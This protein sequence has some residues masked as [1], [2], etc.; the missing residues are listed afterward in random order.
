MKS[1]GLEA[2]FHMG[3]CATAR[4]CAANPCNGRTIF[5][6]APDIPES[7]PSSTPG[8]SSKV[9]TAKLVHVPKTFEEKP[10]SSLLMHRLKDQLEPGESKDP[11]TPGSPPGWLARR[12]TS[13]PEDGPSMTEVTNVAQVRSLTLCHHDFTSQ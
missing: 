13:S 3:N 12:R 11:V 6:P 5:E 2:I 10:K 1:T 9:C 8:A 4:S 7:S